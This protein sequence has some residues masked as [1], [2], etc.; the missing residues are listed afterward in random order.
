[1]ELE[2]NRIRMVVR[3]DEDET[4]IKLNL[5]EAESLSNDLKQALQDYQ[6]RKHVRID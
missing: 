5:E 3:H 1:M 2:R 6:Q 4:V